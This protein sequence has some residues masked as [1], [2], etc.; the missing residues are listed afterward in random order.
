MSD[1]VDARGRAALALMELREVER[2]KLETESPELLGF[3]ETLQKVPTSDAMPSP[4]HRNIMREDGYPLESALYT[5][6]LLS[7]APV[8]DGNRIAVKQVISRNKK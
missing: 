7:Q 1:E 4:D 5:E 3:V 8:R 2:V 6:K